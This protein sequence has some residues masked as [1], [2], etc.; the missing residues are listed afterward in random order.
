[1]SLPWRPDRIRTPYRHR[2]LARNREHHCARPEERDD[3]E[4]A[5]E[6]KERPDDE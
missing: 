6:R 3:T 2:M 5:V 1:M 4:R